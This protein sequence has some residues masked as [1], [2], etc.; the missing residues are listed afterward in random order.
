MI[1][2]SQGKIHYQWRFMA[3]KIICKWVIFQPA[4]VEYRRLWRMCPKKRSRGWIL[5][6]VC[7]IRRD[8]PF[9]G[10]SA[11]EL[12]GEVEIWDSMKNSLHLGELGEG[13]LKIFEDQVTNIYKHGI[14]EVAIFKFQAIIASSPNPIPSVEPG[15][16]KHLGVSCFV[17]CWY[18]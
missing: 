4:M 11:S 1:W 16:G 3:G 10:R 18:N 14:A 12:T 2:H 13:I 7:L 17:S 5:V 15:S 6:W 8:A 9:L